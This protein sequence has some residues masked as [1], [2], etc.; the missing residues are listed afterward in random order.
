MLLRDML[1]E[2]QQLTECWY[3]QIA[4]PSHEERIYRIPRRGGLVRNT[5][6]HTSSEAS[7]TASLRSGIVARWHE[8]ILT[9]CRPW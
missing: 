8:E 4:S 3:L 9:E 6:Y 7:D 5:E 1:G 2:Y